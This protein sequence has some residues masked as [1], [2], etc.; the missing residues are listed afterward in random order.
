[1]IRENEKFFISLIKVADLILIFCAFQ[2]TSI[3][4]P[5]L[6]DMYALTH[7]IYIWFILISL[8]VC[9]LSLRFNDVYNSFRIK[10]IYEELWQVI[11]AGIFALIIINGIVFLFKP[12]Q[13]INQNFIITFSISATLFICL[14]KIFLMIFFR[15]IR[16]KGY[17]YRNLIIIGTENRARN[18][19]KTI[20]EHPQW[21]LRIVGLI[22]KSIEKVGKK[23][24][25]INII[26]TFKD[27]ATIIK[28]EVVDEVVFVVPRSW[29]SE[30]EPVIHECENL[31][32]KVSV[33]LD[34]FNLK[35]GKAYTSELNGIP[36]LRLETVPIRVWQLFVKRQ[37]DI[38]VS[39]VCLIILS[40]LFLLV[41]ILIKL[42]SN[43]PVFFEQTR[44][45]LNGRKF[46]LFK[47]R[48]MVIN[49]EQKQEEILALNEMDGPVF[50]IKNDP[51]ITKIGKYIRALSIDEL[52]QL[53]NVLFGD[54]SLVGPRPPLPKEVEKYESWQRRR[55]SMKPG[56]TCIWQVSGRNK[57]S[58]HE[59][60]KLDLFY[61]D[62]WSL[63]LDLRILLKTIPA[64]LSGHGAR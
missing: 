39:L 64:V 2:F 8:P 31:G 43:G 47:F 42:T 62:N 23:V 55:L 16:I 41:A 10:K 20:L 5:E 9:Y 28:E 3:Y 38:I 18:F 27:V 34:L 53:F 61:I 21:G 44:S 1:M 4:H 52:P 25:N 37:F 46:T 12:L 48:T 60:M 6:K 14:K 36:L 59:W 22:D 26:G 57:I 30:L 40:P 51:R 56:I 13:V 50:K 7:H 11:K 17:N 63:S 45:G 24:H 33:A 58:F 15:Y 32:I 54:M 29:L 19:I 49:A 35:I